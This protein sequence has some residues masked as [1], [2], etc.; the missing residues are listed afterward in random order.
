M[1]VWVPTGRI[2][3]VKGHVFVEKH[4]DPTVK[5]EGGRPNTTF[6]EFQS[7]V[8]PYVKVQMTV[9]AMAVEELIGHFYGSISGS[10]YSYSATTEMVEAGTDFMQVY[11]SEQDSN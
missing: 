8:S 11:A 1:S 2:E 5:V 9:G 3:I 6:L 10:T 4:W 7:E